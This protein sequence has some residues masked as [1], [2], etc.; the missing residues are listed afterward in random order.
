[1]MSKDDR[2][3]LM[4]YLILIFDIFKLVCCPTGLAVLYLKTRFSYKKNTYL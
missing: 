4:F 3:Y 2:I 1:M